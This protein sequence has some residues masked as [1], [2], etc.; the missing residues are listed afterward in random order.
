MKTTEPLIRNISDTALWAAVYRARET[1]RADALF[2]DPLAARLAGAR[3]E[4]IAAAFFAKHHTWSWVT[5]TW[6]FDR[7]ILEQVAQGVDMVVNLAAG[8]DTRPYR[9]TLPPTLRWVEVDLPDLMDYKEALLAN[10]R[11]ACVLQRFRVDLGQ[12]ESRRELFQQLQGRAQRV[13]IVSEGLLIY[14]SPESVGG[15]AE[16]LAGFPGFQRWVLD[17]GSPALLRML[18]Q[19]MGGPLSEA[20]ARFQWAPPEG[21]EFFRAHGWEPLEVHSLLKTAARLRRL[22]W[23]FRLFA[24]FPDTAG[25]KPNRPWGGVCLMSKLQS[26]A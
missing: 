22:S 26:P 11:P 9:M 20:G 4:Q 12:P 25:R 24:C 6:L 3:G 7:I 21:P 1:E 10:E 18:Q 15:L 17:M 14:L 5:R 2:R 19:R 23:L 16:E 8:L 13:L